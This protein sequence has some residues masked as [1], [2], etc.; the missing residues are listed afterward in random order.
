MRLF[1]LDK[2]ENNNSKS[3]K[4]F[5]FI[6]F[7]HIS[8]LRIN[9]L[10]LF[11]DQRFF[12]QKL[13]TEFLAVGT[14]FLFLRFLG[15]YGVFGNNSRRA[16]FLKF[17]SIFPIFYFFDSCNF[18]PGNLH[19]KSQNFPDADWLRPDHVGRGQPS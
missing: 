1:I 19:G 13:V 3:K 11:F 2:K 4:N 7:F 14:L 6:C 8:S 10:P 12:F 17:P 18:E 15:F 5:I 9:F 16:P